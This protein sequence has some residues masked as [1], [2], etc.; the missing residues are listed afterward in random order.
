MPHRLL[1]LDIGS[2]LC[3]HAAAVVVTFTNVSEG[4]KIISLLLAIGYTVWKWFTEYKK[5]KK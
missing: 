5:V 2:V 3:A 1:T 4:L